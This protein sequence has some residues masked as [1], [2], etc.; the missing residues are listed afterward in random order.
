M[1]VSAQTG[2]GKTVAYGLAMSRDL[3]GAGEMMPQAA[4][5]LAPRH[6]ADARAGAAGATRTAMALSICR[7]AHGLL[8]RR[9]GPAHASAA[10][11]QQ[12]A[13]IVVG[14]PGRLRDHL[15]RGRLRV[16]RLEGRGARRGRRDARHGL[17]RGSGIHPRRRRRTDRRTLLFSATMPKG[18]VALAKKYQRNALRIEVAGDGAAM[19]ISNIAPCA[20][21]R[22]EVEKAVVNLL[23]FYELAERAG[24]LQHPRRGA[25]FA[26]HLAGARLFRRRCC[27][28]N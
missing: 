15:E 11:S 5:P 28:A 20:S 14:T 27:P 25:A 21:R 19:P 16:S 3:L 4:A 7:R 17:S 13:Q 9:H 12:G 10:P 22:S 26:G 8:R 18:I 23:R 6:R 24:V 2:S 1:L